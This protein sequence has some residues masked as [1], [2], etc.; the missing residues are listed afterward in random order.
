MDDSL[1]T[2]FSCSSSLVS[3]EA[4]AS[5]DVLSSLR[6]QIGRSESM[7]NEASF[8]LGETFSSRYRMLKKGKSHRSKRE[9][10]ESDFSCAKLSTETHKDKGLAEPHRSL[11]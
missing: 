4:F 3:D 1:L 5:L 11:E 7:T 10:D 9:G 8:S 6:G 2:S